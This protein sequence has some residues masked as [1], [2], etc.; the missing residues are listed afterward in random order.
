MTTSDEEPSS[1]RDPVNRER[2]ART[3]TY[4]RTRLPIL[5]IIARER[6]CAPL[7]DRLPVL[8]AILSDVSFPLTQISSKIVILSRNGSM[9]ALPSPDDHDRLWCSSETMPLPKR[10]FWHRHQFSEREIHHLCPQIHRR[11][12]HPVSGCARYFRRLRPLRRPQR[13]PRL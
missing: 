9:R 11:P 13:R 1:S 6:L 2:H 8:A 12:L 5:T 10:P 7:S 3:L 4:R